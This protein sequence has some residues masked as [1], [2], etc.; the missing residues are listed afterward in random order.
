MSNC[1]SGAANNEAEKESRRRGVRM[2]YRNPGGGEA[3]LS[4]LKMVMQKHSADRL[5][6]DKEISSTEGGGPNGKVKHDM[7]RRK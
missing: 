7:V 4:H 1:A 3:Q 6:F 2:D 5:N